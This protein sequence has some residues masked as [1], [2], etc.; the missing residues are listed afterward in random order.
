MNMKKRIKGIACLLLAC[1]ILVASGCVQ[2]PEDDVVTGKDKI[3]GAHI[4]SV[5]NNVPQ[6]LGQ[7]EHLTDSFDNAA[8]YR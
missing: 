4:E 1:L 3:D 8:V 6:E 5:P 2:T 7:P